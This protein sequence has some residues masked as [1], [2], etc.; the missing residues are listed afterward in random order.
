MGPVNKNTHRLVQH[1]AVCQ[2]RRKVKAFAP[3]SAPPIMQRRTKAHPLPFSRLLW[4]FQL[5]ASNTETSA[6]LHR[7]KDLGPK[8]LLPSPSYKYMSVPLSGTHELRSCRLQRRWHCLRVVT[9]RM[10]TLH[11]RSNAPDTLDCGTHGAFVLLFSW[12]RI[13]ISVATNRDESQR[14]LVQLCYARQLDTD[15]GL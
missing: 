9:T 2:V 6:M 14:N 1:A 11:A 13:S 8:L 10:E 5:R 4:L 3:I 12:F 15:Y 7:V